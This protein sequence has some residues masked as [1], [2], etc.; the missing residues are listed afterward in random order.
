[1]DLTICLRNEESAKAAICTTQS[2]RAASAEASR[3]ARRTPRRSGF[4]DRW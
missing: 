4:I 2:A 3:T 1:M